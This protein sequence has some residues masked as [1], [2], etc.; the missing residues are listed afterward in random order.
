MRPAAAHMQA[1]P[2]K[3][4]FPIACWQQYALLSKT[5]V[6][7]TRWWPC[8]SGLLLKMLITA[9]ARTGWC[10]PLKQWRQPRGSHQLQQQPHAN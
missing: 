7:H 5:Y 10:T 4:T 2:V 3:A 6:P 8:L 1:I 9:H